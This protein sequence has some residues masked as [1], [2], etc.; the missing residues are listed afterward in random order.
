MKEQTVE[1]NQD[2]VVHVYIYITCE[3]AVEP[4]FKSVFKTFEVQRMEKETPTFKKKTFHSHVVPF[5][6]SI[7]WCMLQ[8]SGVLEMPVYWGVC[9]LPTITEQDGTLLVVLSEHVQIQQRC[10][11]S[12]TMTRLLKIIH[13]PHYEQFH[14]GTISSQTTLLT[15]TAQSPGQLVWFLF[16]LPCATDLI[17]EAASLA[18]QTTILGDVCCDWNCRSCFLLFQVSSCVQFIC[19]ISWQP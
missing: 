8:S 4:V 9:L 2:K 16:V 7:F 3:H 13:R 18:E 12:D 17:W 14:G 19:S 11:S 5:L 6:F 10:I 15:S 1:K